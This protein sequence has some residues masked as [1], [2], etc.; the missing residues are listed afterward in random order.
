D[1]I[2]KLSY[3]LFHEHKQNTENELKEWLKLKLEE[4]EFSSKQ[5]Q[6]S[7]DKGITFM[8]LWHKKLYSAI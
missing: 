6:K 3:D 1:A 7:K 2:K 5:L 8:Q 4:D